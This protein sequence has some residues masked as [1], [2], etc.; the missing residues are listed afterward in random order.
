M[1]MKITLLMMAI[2]F[3]AFNANAW[4]LLYPGFENLPAQINVSGPILNATLPV[5]ANPYYTF[6]NTT[7][8]TWGVEF[9]NNGGAGRRVDIATVADPA[10]AANTV[11]SM[12][13]SIVN[14]SAI[15]TGTANDLS[16]NPR[17]AQKIVGVPVGTYTVTFKAKGNVAWVADNGLSYLAL[18][19]RQNGVS[20]LPAYVIASTVAPGSITTSSAN[21]F[22]PFNGITS[23]WQTFSATFDLSTSCSTLASGATIAT[24]TANQNPVISFVIVTPAAAGRIVYIDDVTFMRTS[25][26]TASGTTSYIYNGL[27]QG[28]NTS[29]VS[30]STGI[31]TYSYSGTGGTIYTSS[32]TPPT[33]AGTYQ[34]I[35]SVAADAN[36]LAASSTPYAF[37]INPKPLSISAATIASKIYDGTSLSGTVTPGTLSGFVGTETV[38]VATAIGIYSDANVE[39]GKLAT[40]TYTLANGTNGGL[41]ANYSL[42]NGS[43]TGVITTAMLTLN[44]G[45]AIN[46]SSYTA[47]QL[48]N[49][50]LVVSSGEF[51]VDQPTATV[52][53]VTV[54][55]GAKLSLGL[56]T[57]NTTNG[58]TLQS[59]AS[60]TA[61]LM[62][63]YSS[64]TIN[65][66][67]Q[68]YVEAGRNWYISSPVFDAAYGTLDKG[69]SVV[70][71]NEVTKSWD[72]VTSGTL[73]PGRGYIQV[74]S[75]SQGTTGTVNFTGT[76][77]SGDITVQLTRNGTTQAGFNLVGNPYPSYLD[78][79][80][81]AAAN[82]NVLPTAWFRT[83]KTALAGA[84]YTFATVN[85]ATPSS[86]IIVDN[87]AN[88]SITKCIPPMQAYWVRLIES[89]LT[90]DYKVTNAMRNHADNGGNTFKAPKQNTQQ[91]LRLQVSNGTN[92]DETVIYANPNASNAFEVYDSPKMTSGSASIPE[93]YTLAGGEQ[94][95]I[96]GLN[97]IPYGKEIPIG[98]TTGQSNIFTLKAS[99]IS[100]FD[101]GTKIILTDYFDINNPII[102][103]LSDGKSYS[104]TSDITKNNTS[105]FSIVFK[106]N[107]YTTDV[108]N[109]IDNSNSIV[110]F[111]NSNNQI[112]VIIPTEIIGKSSVTIYNTV[113]QSLENRSLASSTNILSNSYS[114]GVYL[115]SVVANGKIVNRK[116]LIN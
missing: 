52:K 13:N 40:I 26:I 7:G 98:F 111:K 3:S 105:R 97:A 45:S 87:N 92:T 54:A 25:S 76:T 88:T 82:S 113:G 93:I 33:N 71:W 16:V 74:A 18:I 89:P 108:I 80:Q 31:K 65:A 99:Q 72:P 38:T 84:S 86:P 61:T 64:P 102:S 53:S 106:T 58:I 66:V 27:S 39:T 115:V 43:A 59:D 109:S 30:G 90:T 103:D 85:V 44:S 104:Y 78:W 116:V 56:N 41:A 36:C 23:T 107:S 75:A 8:G 28:P 110:V 51:V 22:A 4:S 50:D 1:K 100:N 42:A 15:N 5:V 14:A 114:S 73:T 91:L 94:L 70:E 29:T 55:P 21:G 68:Q 9:G 96:N 79:S 6:N 62:D 2:C 19:I 11:A 12:T 63:S 35:A 77:N 95:V 83:K 32:T 48:A 46:A 34:V 17:L 69:N 67:V 47:P 49:S 10:D 101:A 37:T 57:L 20:N 60:G 24:Y 81:V 112:E